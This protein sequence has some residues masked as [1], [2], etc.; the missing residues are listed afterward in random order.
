MNKPKLASIVIALLLIAAAG[1][2]WHSTSKADPINKTVVVSGKV[3]VVF[4]Y[5]PA[6]KA[7]KLDPIE[8]L[9]YE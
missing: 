4:G 6:W 9:R 3:G 5:Y 7:S 2:Y 8:A 1:W